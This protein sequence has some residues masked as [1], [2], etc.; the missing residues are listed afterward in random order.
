ML[1]FQ[2]FTFPDQLLFKYTEESPLFCS[3]WCVKFSFV[4][5]IPSF[6][7]RSPY[8]KNLKESQALLKKNQ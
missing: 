5:K 2:L 6:I 1:I 7:I 3:S 4:M 8:P